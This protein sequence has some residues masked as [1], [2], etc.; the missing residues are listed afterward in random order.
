MD[1]TVKPMPSFIQAAIDRRIGYQRIVARLPSITDF[2]GDDPTN[3]YRN[4]EF[5]RA[6][7]AARGT[8]AMACHASA[9]NR[10]GA[11]VS[12]DE[13]GTN[14]AEIFSQCLVRLYLDDVDILPGWP[15]QDVNRWLASRGELSPKNPTT[16]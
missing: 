9:E 12:V 13:I 3:R 1:D 14:D 6:Y 16:K 11:I 2:M 10:K 4:V 7:N 15:P 5:S 8:F